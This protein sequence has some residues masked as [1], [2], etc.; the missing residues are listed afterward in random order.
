MLEFRA[1]RAPVT[2]ANFMRYVE[3]GRYN[4]ASFYWA[5]RAKNQ[6]TQGLIESG[7]QNDPAKLLPPIAHE[8][9]ALTGLRHE[10]GVISMAREAPGIKHLGR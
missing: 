1:D 10:D 2:C 8:S 9:T 3:G 4:G 7:L 5:V 6:P